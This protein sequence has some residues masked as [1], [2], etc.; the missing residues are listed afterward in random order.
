M[1][2]WETKEWKAMRAG[3][4]EGKSCS[5]CGSNEHLV[6][7]NCNPPP[8]YNMLLRQVSS[9]LLQKKIEAGE[10]VTNKEE[11]LLCPECGS[12]SLRHRT[13]KK[14]AYKCQNCRAEFDNPRFEIVDTGRLPREDWDRFWAKFGPEIK[15]NVSAMQRALS[16]DGLRLENYAA[17]CRR[18]HMA[19]RSGFILCPVCKKGYARQGREMCWACF[20]KTEKGMEIALQYEKEP[21]KHPWCGKEFMIEHRWIGLFSEPAVLCVEMCELG[22]D[23]C[24]EAKRRIEEPQTEK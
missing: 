19:S 3:F 23:N 17:L 16:A 18:C 24:V 21:L 11:R 22:P 5:W 9:A 12:A 6:M 8:S 10:F 1:K 7:H 15:E 4:L 13:Q 20:K 2:A 14:P